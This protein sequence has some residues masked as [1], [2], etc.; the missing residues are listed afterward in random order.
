LRAGCPARRSLWERSIF[1]KKNLRRYENGLS[2]SFGGYFALDA[3]AASQA[4]VFGVA[5]GD[6]QRQGC[7]SAPAFFFTLRS[8][9]PGHAWN[10]ATGQQRGYIED[11]LVSQAPMEESAERV[12]ATFDQDRPGPALG[13][14]A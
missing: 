1:G 8:V 10:G 14:G 13:E 6:W 11:G 4:D 7:D 2:F 5:Q 3:D 9:W 12:A